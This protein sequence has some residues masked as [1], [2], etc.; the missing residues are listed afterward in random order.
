M[1]KK[2]LNIGHFFAVLGILFMLIGV[3]QTINRINT[4]VV[5][6]SIKLDSVI[7]KDKKRQFNDSIQLEKLMTIVKTNTEI[8]GEIK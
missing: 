8:L 2:F 4:K 6:T 1:F 5:D 3:Y 7:I